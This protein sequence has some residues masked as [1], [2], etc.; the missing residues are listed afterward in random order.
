MSDMKQSK[1]HVHIDDTHACRL[2]FLRRN[3]NM[4][5]P[6]ALYMLGD[7]GGSESTG[8]DEDARCDD[9]LVR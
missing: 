5:L 3:V 8:G 6:S 9:S 2:P 1:G 4:E 7:Y